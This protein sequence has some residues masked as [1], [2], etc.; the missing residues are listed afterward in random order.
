MQTGKND[1]NYKKFTNLVTENYGRKYYQ[2]ISKAI[3]HGGNHD[4]V[5]LNIALQ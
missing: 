2:H 5:S 3:F 1:T 4:T